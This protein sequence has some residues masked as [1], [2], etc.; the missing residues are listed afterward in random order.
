MALV[1]KA[2]Q[3]SFILDNKRSFDYLFGFVTLGSESAQDDKKSL[4]CYLFMKLLTYIQ[5]NYGIA[6]RTITEAIKEQRV[7]LDEKPVE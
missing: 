4:F 1:C 5:Q 7:F 3:K 2:I 6:R